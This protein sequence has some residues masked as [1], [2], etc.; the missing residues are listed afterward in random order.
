MNTYEMLLSVR[1]NIGETVAAHWTDVNLLR[2]INAAQKEIYVKVANAPGDWLLKKSA[3]L[4]PVDSVVSLPA[5]CLFPA[6]LEDV[7]TGVPIYLNGSVRERS[8]GRLP[9]MPLYAGKLEAYFVGNTVEINQD[10][11]GL[12]CYLWYQPRLIDLHAGV[13]G[14]GSDAT[15][16][17]F[18]LTG[19]PSGVDSYYVGATIEVRDQ[20][21]NVLDVSMPITGYVGATGVAAVTSTAVTPTTRDFY[22]T[23]S[24]LPIEL[25][26]WL[27]LKATMKALAKPSS[28]FEKE[29]F[30][31]WRNVLAETEEAMNNFLSSRFSGS[32][33]TRIAEDV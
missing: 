12:P 8:R 28:T 15:H 7:S 30:G 27:V 19:W 1:D 21:T 31:F 26:E 23:V 10:G 29:V 32:T 14:S 13:C 4:T 17:G 25:H 16:V 33:Y 20:N 22:G 2:R 18:D 9:N 3:A 24:Q 11:Y 6:Y 5:D